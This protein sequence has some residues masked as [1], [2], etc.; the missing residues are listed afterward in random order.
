V[1]AKRACLRAA[2]IQ[3]KVRRRKPDDHNAA[4]VVITA[5]T[6][7]PAFVGLYKDI[8]RARRYEPEVRANA[9]AFD[10]VVERR[11]NVTIA[12]GGRPGAKARRTVR[13]CVF[14]RRG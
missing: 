8:A 10:G 11:G 7:V 9:E 2:G 1:R 5:F 3:S 14:E 12:W 13:R 4:D 6:R